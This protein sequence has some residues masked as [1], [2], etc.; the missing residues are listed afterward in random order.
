MPDSSRAVPV[1]CPAAPVAFKALAPGQARMVQS[2]RQLTIAEAGQLLLSARTGEGGLIP[3]LRSTAYASPAPVLCGPGG[4]IALTRYTDC[5][6]TFRHHGL[7]VPAD[8]IT[9]WALRGVADDDSRK[10]LS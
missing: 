5:E 2:R 3:T 4:F 10:A 1:G 8:G 7:G 9:G 6:A